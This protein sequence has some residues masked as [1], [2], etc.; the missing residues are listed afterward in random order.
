MTALMSSPAP[1]SKM[2]HNPTTTNPSMTKIIP[3]HLNPCNFIRK[4]ATESNPVKIITAP[5]IP[6][7]LKFT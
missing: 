1:L 3:N 2:S 5:I 6:E 4:N 7:L